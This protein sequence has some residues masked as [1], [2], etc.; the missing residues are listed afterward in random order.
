M[1]AV[2]PIGPEEGPA[3]SV[4]VE[5]KLPDRHPHPLAVSFGP[6]R[7]ALENRDGP[8]AH[9]NFDS[10]LVAELRRRP[11]F[12]EHPDLLQIQVR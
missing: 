10:H 4:G 12:A 1:P 7:P 6:R 5:A 11:F 3:C 8:A 2:V 9:S